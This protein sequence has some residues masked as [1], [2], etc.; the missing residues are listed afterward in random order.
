MKPLT[1]LAGGLALTG[2]LA[3]PASAQNLKKYQDKAAFTADTSATSA[4]GALPDH[5]RVL[6]VE[7]DPVG[8]YPLGSL[9]LSLPPG[10]DNVAVGASGTS[11]DPDWYPDPAHTND[12]AM[13]WEHLQV[14]M[15]GPVYA[16]GFDFIE[17]DATMPAWGGTPVESTYE[18]LLFN[19]A[20]FVGRLQFDGAAIP[21]DVQTFIGVWSDR[22]FNR[23]IINDVTGSDDDEF[24]GEFYT[25]TAP[26]GCTMDLDLSYAG[27]TFTMNVGLGTSIP[28]T[29][30]LWFVYGENALV[31]IVSAPVPVIPGVLALP[32]SFT[33]PPL[34]EVGLLSTL[35]TASEGIAC[36]AFKTISTAP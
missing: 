1:V 19:G 7:T 31:P 4:S 36:S 8:V 9:L 6:D 15:P 34:G 33:L 23:V 30:N 21:N 29:W 12:I 22:P 28:R 32:F 27:G 17:P 35:Q 16:F 2:V 25:S 18:L 24:F 20:N 3:A 13:G 26:F 5:G 11:A 14:T 10:G